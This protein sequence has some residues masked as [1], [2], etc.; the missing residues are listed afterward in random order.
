MKITD[1]FMLVSVVAAF[2]YAEGML[3]TVI[4]GCAVVYAIARILRKA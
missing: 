1:L 2:M 4:L 3:R